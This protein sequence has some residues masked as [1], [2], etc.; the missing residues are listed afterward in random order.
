MEPEDRKA[1]AELRNS[2]L[3]TARA[4][5]LKEAMMGFLSAASPHERRQRIINA[6]IQG[7][8]YTARNFRNTN[9]FINAICFHC[10]RSSGSETAV[11][12]F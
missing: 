12:M 11:F 5:A 3:K 8:K 6:R 10:G 9:N 4:W 1:F 2:G 7:V